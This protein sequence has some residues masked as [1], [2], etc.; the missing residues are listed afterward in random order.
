[1]T[2]EF[3]E[4]V[5]H[6]Y[7]PWMAQYLVKRAGIEPNLHFLYVA[8]IDYLEDMPLVELVLQETYSQIRGILLAD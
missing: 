5:S 6:T 2:N 8:F 4:A 3:R 1:M 7:L